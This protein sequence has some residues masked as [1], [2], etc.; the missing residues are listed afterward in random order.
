MNK[1]V[2]IL[3]A[4]ISL[5][6][7]SCGNENDDIDD[8]GGGT[9]SNALVG[10]WAIVRQDDFYTTDYHVIGNVCD[11]YYVFKKNGTYE[12]YDFEEEPFCAQFQSGNLLT[13]DGNPGELF[14]YGQYKYDKN[15]WLWLD[16]LKVGQL[17][18]SSNSGTFYDGYDRYT[19]KKITGFKKWNLQKGINDD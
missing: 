14:E 17:K 11:E 6:L 3:F 4:F 15:G 19:V 2:S 1:F 10:S 7:L 18:L 5:T 13:I 9:N 8:I 16:G 12:V